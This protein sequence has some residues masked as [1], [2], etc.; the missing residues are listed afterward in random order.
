MWQ[1]CQNA[2]A[3][4]ITGNRAGGSHSLDAT[5]DELCNETSLPVGTISKSQRVM[6]DRRYAEAC[7][8]RLLNYAD[9]FDNLVG[10]G[11]LFV[12][13][14]CAYRDFSS[15][16]NS[17]RSSGRIVADSEV[18]SVRCRTFSIVGC[19]S[20]DPRSRISTRWSPTIGPRSAGRL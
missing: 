19:G 6:T 14:D 12:P 2:G 7:V 17:F 15:K 3:V 18:R 9:S 4:L 13:C 10:T 8:L 1:A 11:R 20:T 5:I 16:V